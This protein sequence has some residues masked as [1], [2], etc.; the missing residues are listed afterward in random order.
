M[1]QENAVTYGYEVRT[2]K[3]N[4]I[5]EKNGIDLLVVPHVLSPRVEMEQKTPQM[6]TNLSRTQGRIDR[7]PSLNASRFDLINKDPKVG[8]MVKHVPQ[9]Q[10]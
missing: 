1:W 6:L 9:V 2:D 5:K 10:F 7:F 4:I 3:Y 8:S